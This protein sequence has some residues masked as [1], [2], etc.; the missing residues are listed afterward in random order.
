MA[1]IAALQAENAALKQQN[2]SLEIRLAAAHDKIASLQQ[3]LEGETHMRRTAQTALE[4]ANEAVVENETLKAEVASLKDENNCLERKNFEFQLQADDYQASLDLA[5]KTLRRV[6]PHLV[7]PGKVLKPSWTT[8]AFAAL[9]L[10][11]KW[12]RDECV[13]DL[14]RQLDEHLSMITALKSGRELMMDDVVKAMN[15][16]GDVRMMAEFDASLHYV[17]HELREQLQVIFESFP[18]KSAHE[19]WFKF[20]L[21]MFTLDYAP[22]MEDVSDILEAMEEDNA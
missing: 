22:D 6:C 11:R 17:L 15:E 7:G 18:A 14:K 2:E 4:A 19:E 10:V 16:D 21:R 8:T 5:T 1:S 13:A 3:F 9:D 20:P 12:D